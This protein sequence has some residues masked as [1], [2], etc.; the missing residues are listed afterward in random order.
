MK[1]RA[2]FF[3]LFFLGLSAI[4]AYASEKA[5]P[6]KPYIDY[7]MEHI[8]DANE[9]HLFGSVHIP[10]PCILYSKDAGLEVFMSSA[11]EHGHQVVNG[12]VLDHGDV[13]RIKGW[14]ESDASGVYRLHGLPRPTPMEGKGFN[15]SPTTTEKPTRWKNLRP[16]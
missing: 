5:E 3:L 1:F 10:L 7:V 16:C 8:A 14:N 12:Y 6:E 2:L 11:F 9:F 13:K 15:T 4:R